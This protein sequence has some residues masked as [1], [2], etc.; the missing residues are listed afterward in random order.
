MR[1]MLTRSALPH[2]SSPLRGDVGRPATAYSE[3]SDYAIIPNVSGA[4][5]R[6]RDPTK[7]DFF[8]KREVKP[9]RELVTPTEGVLDGRYLDS[10]LSI[11]ESPINPASTNSTRSIV[12]CCRLGRSRNERNSVY[13]DH[14][15][16]QCCT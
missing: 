4:G 13:S 6:V 3:A 7:C 12:P 15:A 5:V 8:P 11:P 1:S 16:S 9:G 2:S 14:R 10:G